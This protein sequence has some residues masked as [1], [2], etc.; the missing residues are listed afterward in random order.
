MASEIAGSLGELLRVDRNN[1]FSADRG[2]CVALS[3]VGA[4]KMQVGVRNKMS[5]ELII[6]NMDY[7][8]LPICCRYCLATTH[9]V[10]NCPLLA[11]PVEGR[12]AANIGMVSSEAGRPELADD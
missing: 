1:K 4:W 6:I 11:R 10:C 7:G 5:V 9:L 12:E 8:H 2:T 3:T